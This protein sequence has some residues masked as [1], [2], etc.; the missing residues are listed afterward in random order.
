MTDTVQLVLG[1]LIF[2]LLFGHLLGTVIGP[3]MTG[4]RQS[5]FSI[6]TLFWIWDPVLGLKQ[7]VVTVITWIHGC[8]GLVIWMR[9]QSWW[10]RGRRVRLSTGRRHPP[11]CHAG[12]GRSRQGSNRT[13]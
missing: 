9:I 2:P 1:L 7:V 10:P 5:Y 12:H 8:M 6:L 3:L 13:Q 4:T 11:A